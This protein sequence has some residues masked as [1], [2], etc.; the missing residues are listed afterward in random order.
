MADK[1]NFRFKVLALVVALVT[2]TLFAQVIPGVGC[3]DGW[4][5]LSIGQ[6]GACSSHGG[7]GSSGEVWLSALVIVFL[8]GVGFYGIINNF[9]SVLGTLAKLIQLSSFV[10]FFVALSLFANK[11]G[12]SGFLGLLASFGI[13]FSVAGLGLLLEKLQEYIEQRAFDN[14]DHDWKPID[15]GDFTHSCTKCHGVNGYKHT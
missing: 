3:N 15:G 7:V 13:M 9:E 4:A 5:S 2:L 1:K 11:S 14:C 12:V 10:M 8:V 6:P